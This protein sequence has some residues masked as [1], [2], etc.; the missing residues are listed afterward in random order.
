MVGPKAG[1]SNGEQEC[2]G[3]NFGKERCESIGCCH[4]KDGQCWSSVGTGSC[5][6][7]SGEQVCEGHNFGK[8][9]CESIGCCHYKD[10]Q[11]LSSVGT[12][13][14]GGSGEQVCEGHNFGKERCESIGCCHFN[15]GQCLSSVGTGS[16]GEGSGEQVCEGHNLG[17]ER[18]ESIGC[19]HYKDGQCWSSVGAGSCRI[20][21]VF[22]EFGLS[23]EEVKELKAVFE[24]VDANRD[25]RIVAREL[26]ESGRTLHE[27]IT[28]TVAEKMVMAAI[29]AHDD[30][31]HDEDHDHYNE[32]HHE[33]DERMHNGVGFE[34]FVHLVMFAPTFNRNVLVHYWVH[35]AG[36]H[37]GHTHNFETKGYKDADYRY[38]RH[39]YNV[40]LSL[41]QT[42]DG[43]LDP[44]DLILAFHEMESTQLGGNRPTDR[45]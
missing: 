18:C 38:E 13:S 36:H 32:E 26:Y 41:D 19:C 23:A 14:C 37:Y 6:G 4:Y 31:G 8:E 16:C 5:V 15:D 2:E 28:L 34:I 43:V 10:G 12:G 35:A 42:H 25:G 20:S 30:H 3:H 44:V 40:F 39:F 29:E 9:R 17:K 22:H 27:P 21:P 33:E 11:C 24:S 7:R 45:L 1:G